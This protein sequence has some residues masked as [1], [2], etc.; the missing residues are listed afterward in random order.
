M[1]KP[2]HA[3]PIT[4]Q[5]HKEWYHGSP[6]RIDTLCAGST[7]TPVPDLARAFSHKPTRLDITIRE[8]DGERIVTIRHNG[9]QSGF[10]YRVQVGDP[11]QDLRPHPTS[12]CAPGEEVLATRD[13]PL[14]FISEVPLVGE[15]E[16][17]QPRKQKGGQRG[18]ETV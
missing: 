18:Y 8:K 15:Y 7:V 4:T 6:L 1:T 2:T 11:A 17:R 10:L 13:L 3:P 16:S 5:Q 12:T 9:R 14:E